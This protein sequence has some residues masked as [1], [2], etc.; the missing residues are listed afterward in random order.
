MN[1]ANYSRW[2][3]ACTFTTDSE[4]RLEPTK[5]FRALSV[6]GF[7]PM[8]YRDA[9]TEEIS[10]LIPKVERERFEAFKVL[11]GVRMELE[12]RE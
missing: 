11:V 7:T 8:W 9:V 1:R 6:V 12:K 5:V 3:T 2:F 10:I 4:Q